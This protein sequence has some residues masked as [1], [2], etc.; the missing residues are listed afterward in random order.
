MSAA[1]RSCI[2]MYSRQTVWL[3][4]SSPKFGSHKMLSNLPCELRF[5]TGTSFGCSVN[6]MA[7]LVGLRPSLN[8]SD[9]SNIDH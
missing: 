5:A 1:N 8:F 4:N 6:L 7:R 2:G 3:P 9:V